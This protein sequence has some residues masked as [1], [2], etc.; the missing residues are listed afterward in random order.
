[1]SKILKQCVSHQMLNLSKLTKF[2][3]GQADGLANCGFTNAIGRCYFNWLLETTAIFDQQALVSM[4][5]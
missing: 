1:M 5:I 4:Y 3:D 2:Q